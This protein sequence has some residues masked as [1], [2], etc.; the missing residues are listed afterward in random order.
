MTGQDVVVE[1]LAKLFV[2]NAGHRPVVGI[3]GG[4]AD[5]DVDPP[6]EPVRLV[7]EA[8]EILL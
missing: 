2:G 6:E 1:N 5:E 7:D 8:L 3:G 4:V